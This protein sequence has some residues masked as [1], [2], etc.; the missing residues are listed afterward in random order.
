MTYLKNHKCKICGKK[1]ERNKRQCGMCSLCF[2]RKRSKE[3]KMIEYRK[4]YYKEWFQK[5]KKDKER[6]KKW[7]I[8]NILAQKK[9]GN[10]T[11]TNRA[12]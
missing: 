6:Y 4:K 7:R 9:Y 8:K 11:T 12:N 1:T 3:L 5:L 2:W 10:K